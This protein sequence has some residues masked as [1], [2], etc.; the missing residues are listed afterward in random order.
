V[1]T[2]PFIMRDRAWVLQVVGDLLRIIVSG[3]L[4]RWI[5]QSVRFIAGMMI[6]R[7]LSGGRVC[8]KFLFPPHPPAHAPRERRCVFTQLLIPVKCKQR[9]IASLGLGDLAAD[10]RA[11]LVVDQVGHMQNF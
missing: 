7:L 4:N 2:H 9:D 8:L 5:A 11:F 6:L 1:E 3:I 10:N